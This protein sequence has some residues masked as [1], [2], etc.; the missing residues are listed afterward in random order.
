MAGNAWESLPH[1]HACSRAYRWNED[2]IAGVCDRHQYICFAIALWNGRAPIRNERLFGLTGNKGNHRL[3]SL[4]R[5]WSRRTGGAAGAAPI[6][7]PSVKERPVD[8]T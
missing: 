2:S 8:C 3:N 1:D 6:L 7:P 5:A 4:T